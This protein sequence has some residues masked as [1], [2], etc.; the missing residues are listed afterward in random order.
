V[1]V[2]PSAEADGRLSALIGR[3]APRAPDRASLEAWGRALGAVLP[4]PSAIA[5]SGDLGAGKTT[6]VRAICEG[7]GVSDLSA[8]TSPTFALI[9][10]YPAPDG[11]VLHADLYRLQRRAELDALGWDDLVATA[12][13]LLVEWPEHALPGL[14]SGTILVELR[15]DPTLADRR[16]LAVRRL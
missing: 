4:R 16:T 15:H 12:R 1:A 8:V 10:E 9:Q 11:P 5:L 6:L 2:D 7:V 13:V 3:D 14:P